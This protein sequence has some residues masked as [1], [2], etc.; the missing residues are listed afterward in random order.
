M[1]HEQRSQFRQKHSW[2]MLAVLSL[3]LASCKDKNTYHVYLNAEGRVV[4]DKGK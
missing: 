3:A 1:M 2:A 4:V